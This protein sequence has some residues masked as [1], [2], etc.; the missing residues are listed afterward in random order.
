M[1]YRLYLHPLARF[2]G[3]KLAAATHL[4][5]AYWMLIKG[6]QYT[7]ILPELH[8]KYGRDLYNAVSAHISHLTSTWCI[9]PIVR[10]YPDELHIHDMDAYNEVFS[11]GTKFD[12]KAQFYDHPLLE[13][14][15]RLPRT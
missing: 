1:I 3:P 9:G 5:G 6:G 2:L 4:Y 7:L 10:T 13:A 8:Q 15:T 12:K 14:I 11:V